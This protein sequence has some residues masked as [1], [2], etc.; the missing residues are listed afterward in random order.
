MYA[1]YLDSVQLP[2]TPSKLSTR[3]KN[4][5][6]TI[7]L[8]SG[9]E[10]NILKVAGLTD[11]ELTA[12]IPQVRYPFA[13][14]PNGFKDAAF[15]LEKLEALKLSKKPFQFIVSRVS[16][17]GKLLFDTNLTV[18]VEDYSIDED[19]DN[20]LDVEI[21]INLK[22]FV[23]FGTKKAVIKQAASTGKKTAKVTKKRAS[24]KTTPKTHTVVKGDTLWAICKKY[25]GSGTKYPEIAKLNKIKNPNLIYPK[26]VIKLG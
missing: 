24:T 17:S 18:S 9:E 2:V 8:I 4:Q 5:N 10:I 12:T 15:Y 11:V 25:L 7:N 6:K 23:P 19:A 14:Y 16:P 20:G 21:S 13:V 3:I 22:Q 1:F 26:Q